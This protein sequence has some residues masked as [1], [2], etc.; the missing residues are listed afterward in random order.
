MLVFILLTTYKRGRPRGRLRQNIQRSHLILSRL[1]LL[2]SALVEGILPTDFSASSSLMTRGEE[3]NMYQ[4]MMI[5][6]VYHR[7]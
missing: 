5:I 1:H 2:S 7:L 6:S 4:Y 3:M